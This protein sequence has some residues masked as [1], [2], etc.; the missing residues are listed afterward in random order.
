MLISQ[1]FSALQNYLFA[2]NELNPAPAACYD[3]ICDRG[4]DWI[5]L[6]A[7]RRA[8]DGSMR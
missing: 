4:V 1:Y 8:A 7:N 5:G 6:Y 2:H 3:I